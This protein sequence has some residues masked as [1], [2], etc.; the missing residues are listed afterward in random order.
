MS[1]GWPRCA[2]SQE[3]GKVTC[4]ALLS[5]IIQSETFLLASLRQVGLPENLSGNLDF[6]RVTLS[7]PYC[8]DVIGEWD[9]VNLAGF[10]NFL[11]QFLSVC[12]L[13]Y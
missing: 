13:S 9:L 2:H 1:S 8:L 3:A 11:G 10:R 4:Q 5:P 6:L 7:S 12:F